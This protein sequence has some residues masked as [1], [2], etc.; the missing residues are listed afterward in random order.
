MFKVFVF[1]NHLFY[2]ETCVEDHSFPVLR[3]IR[4]F[5]DES[6]RLLYYIRDISLILIIFRKDE[7]VSEFQDLDIEWIFFAIAQIVSD[8]AELW[9]FDEI[10][11]FIFIT[12]M[13]ANDFELELLYAFRIYFR[14]IIN[15][16][17]W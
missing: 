9:V 14:L 13:Q 11:L 16:S 12:T 15:S 17:A 7:F 8:K 5:N 3:V 6:E 1:D 10:D 4:S 2:G